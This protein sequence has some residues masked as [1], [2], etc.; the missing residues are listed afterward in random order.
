MMAGERNGRKEAVMSGHD[1]IVI[2]ASA[3]GVEALKVLAS[4]LPYDLPAAVC[5]VLHVSP[6]GPSLLPE[7]LTRA[8]SLPANQ[9]VKEEVIRPGRIYVAP[10]DHHLVI[11]QGYVRVTRGP[12]ENRFR[13][14]VDVLFILR[15]PPAPAAQIDT[16][17]SQPRGL[18][19]PRPK[20]S[21]VRLLTTSLNA[22][23]FPLES[24]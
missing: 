23:Q 21:F 11:E 3:G 7:I 20:S 10:P 8:G 22:L 15:H 24:A 16:R 2:G 13:P 17:S 14:A 6:T 18:R 9:V 4:G 12:K 5:V 1:L 19:T